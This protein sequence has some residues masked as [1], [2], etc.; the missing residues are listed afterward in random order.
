MVKIYTPKELGIEDE[1][2]FLWDP[3]HDGFKWVTEESIQEQDRWHTYYSRVA[4]RVSDNTYWE[5][6]WATGSTEYQECDLD[7]EVYQVEPVEVT[8]TQYKLVKTS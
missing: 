2:E 7:L 4:Q 3:E 1:G 8:T 6:S 5:F